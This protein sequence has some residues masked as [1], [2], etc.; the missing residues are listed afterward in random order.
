[1][2]ASDAERDRTIP[3]GTEYKCQDSGQ[4]NKRK[5][6]PSSVSNSR[7]RA[8]SGFG[9]AW[10]RPREARANRVGGFKK[11]RA[12]LSGHWRSH[13]QV[14]QMGS[15]LGQRAKDA[16]VKLLLLGKRRS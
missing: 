3:W 5:T 1:M 2:G 10:P 6:N 11:G 9:R 4:N 7:P 8:N 14:P 16:R 12:Q 13:R 15:V